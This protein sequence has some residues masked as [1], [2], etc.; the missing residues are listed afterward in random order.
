MLF[1]KIIFIFLILIYII[2]AFCFALN[3]EDI[4]VWSNNSTSIQTS[5]SPS[6][7]EQEKAI[8]NERKFFRHYFWK[9]HFNGAKNWRDSLR[10]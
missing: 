10:V 5:I 3:Q 9:C 1:K 7:E 6:P 8:E 4:Y 2:P